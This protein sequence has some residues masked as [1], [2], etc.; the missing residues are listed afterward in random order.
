M[1][2]LCSH[3]KGKVTVAPT[4]N[5]LAGE[6]MHEER[7]AATLSPEM[8]EWFDVKDVEALV[9]R[10]ETIFG[11]TPPLR[12]N[13]LEAVQYDTLAASFSDAHTIIPEKE[14]T[15]IER[16]AIAALQTMSSQVTTA[17]YRRVAEW[18]EFLADRIAIA[19]GQHSGTTTRARFT[20]TEADAAALLHSL[21]PLLA[22]AYVGGWEDNAE[23]CA[24]PQPKRDD[25]N[26]PIDEWIDKWANINEQLCTVERTAAIAIQQHLGPQHGWTVRAFARAVNAIDNAGVHEVIAYLEAND[27]S[28]ADPTAAATRVAKKVEPKLNAGDQGMQIHLVVANAKRSALRFQVNVERHAVESA[29][30]TVNATDAKAAHAKALTHE[31]AIWQR[32][33]DTENRT[34]GKVMPMEWI[35]APR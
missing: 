7:L 4:N 26:G 23:R 12:R 21:D 22:S 16:A 14:W 29:T 11:E 10:V 25:S 30:L 3:A 20:K 31:H 24:R 27:R 33:G 5:N 18:A 2:N 8:L 9:K 32:Q 35:V 6:R 17:Q 34:V 15:K 13:R 1:Q 19:R 28:G